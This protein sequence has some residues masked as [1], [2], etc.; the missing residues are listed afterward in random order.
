MKIL[1]AVDGSEYGLAAVEEAARMPWPEGS[2]IRIVSVAELPTT[3]LAWGMPMS[4]GTNEEWEKLFE[5]RTGENVAQAMARFGEIAGT[6]VE[7]TAK[8]L[9]GDPKAA[10]LDE[11]R[12]WGADLIVVGTHGYGTFERI[13]LGSVSRAIASNA[14]CAV[15][16]VRRPNVPIEA[17]K[18]MKI[19]LAVDGSKFSDATVEEI[20]TRPWPQGSE[21]RV[22]SA[23]HLQFAPTPEVWALP[24]GYYA[25]VEETMRKQGESAVQHAASRLRDSNSERSDAPLTVT[26]EVIVGHAEEIIIEVAKKWNANLIL[27]GSHGHSGLGRFLLGSVSQ[28]V[29]S[30]APCS[31]EIVRKNVA[32]EAAK[33]EER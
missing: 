23:L 32:S 27:L 13:W 3:A 9:K 22:L 2:L 4:S 14:D 25:R 10:I 17:G 31:V 1:V 6:Q 16:I 11:A 19:L 24:D 5:D 26:T 29:A 28:A 18:G 20:A 33:Q 8:T 7:A 30:H 21:I 12:H 15:R